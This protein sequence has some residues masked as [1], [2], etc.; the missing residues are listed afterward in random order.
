MAQKKKAQLKRAKSGKVAPAKEVKKTFSCAERAKGFAEIARPIE[1]SKSLLNMVLA[2]LM[3][4]YVFG[5]ATN[6]FV[7]V[8]GF[9]SVALLWSGL[10]ALNDYTDRKIDA[11]HDVKKNRPIPCGKVSPLQGLAFSF[12]MIIIAFLLAVF[13]GNAMLGGC[14]A[15]MLIN[16]LLYTT[17]PFRL[18]SRKGFDLVSGSMINP[19][20]R[21]MSGI[22]LFVPAAVFFTSIPPILPIIFVVGIQFSGYFLYRLFSKSHD[23]K[24]KMKSSVAVMSKKHIKRISHLVMLAA[25]LSYFAMLFNGLGITFF[26]FGFPV[27][28]FL[29]PQYFLAILIVAAFFPFIKGAVK[30]PLNA[31]MKSNYR[32][33]YVMNIA[34]VVGNAIIFIL[35]R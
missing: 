12:L 30:N 1:W 21:Y 13:L 10:Y 31:D 16:Q 3:A 25:V 14:L 17:K 29:P 19:L 34:F 26:N 33:L 4:C 23:I 22:V 2:T 8:I 32:A 15:I 9:F 35:L 28:G 24:L 11:L 27:L 18:K 6:F 7:F 20:F 5:A